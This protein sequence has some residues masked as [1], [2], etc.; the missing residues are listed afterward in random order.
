MSKK[1][2]ATIHPNIN[3][4]YE[5]DE[6]RSKELPAINYNKPVWK[7]FPEKKQ[8]AKSGRCVDCDQPITSTDDF[9]DEISIREYSLSGLCQRCQ[10]AIFR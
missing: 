9:T 8:R 4:C 3:H 2:P 7:M 6:Y 10:D 1:P 5:W